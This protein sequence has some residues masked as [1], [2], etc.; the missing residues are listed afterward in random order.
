MNA[1]KKRCSCYAVLEAFM[2]GKDWILIWWH[3]D[4]GF[5]LHSRD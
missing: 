5:D 4:A 1:R 2:R 3:R